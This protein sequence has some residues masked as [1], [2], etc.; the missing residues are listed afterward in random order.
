MTVPLT[1]AGLPRLKIRAARQVALGGV[2]GLSRLEPEADRPRRLRALGGELLGRR[3]PRQRRPLA[4]S[5]RNETTVGCAACSELMSIAGAS[6]H[7]APPA[8]AGS[9]KAAP[10]NGE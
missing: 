2:V 4:T 1:H 3:C 7:V 5:P 8:L 9:N 6:S 10:A